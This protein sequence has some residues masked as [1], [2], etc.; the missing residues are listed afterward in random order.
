M[1]IKSFLVLTALLIFALSLFAPLMAADEAAPKEEPAVATEKPAGPPAMEAPAAQPA[2]APSAEEPAASPAMKTEQPAPSKAES[3]SALHVE[4]MVICKEIQD[5]KLVGEATTFPGSV[6][7]LFCQS[8]VQGA[9]EE[10]TVHHVWYWNNQKMAD[11]PLNIRTSSFNTY[12][13]KK[14]LAQWKGAWRV[15]LLGPQGDV[16]S[17]ASFTVE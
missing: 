5:R 3:A 15:D 17:S 8:L 2:P 7:K 9:K 10:T 4:K 6:E 11:I 14:I 13:S 16:L 1:S 12:S